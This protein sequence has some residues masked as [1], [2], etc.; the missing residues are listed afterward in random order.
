MRIIVPPAGR[1]RFLEENES[2]LRFRRNKIRRFTECTAS[3]NRP[4]IIVVVTNV[5][6][7]REILKGEKKST[8]PDT[9]MTVRAFCSMLL[10][11]PGSMSFNWSSL[12]W[13]DALLDKAAVER[14]ETFEKTTAFTIINIFYLFRKQWTWAWIMTKTCRNITFWS[15]VNAPL[16][17]KTRN[18]WSGE[19]Y[20]SG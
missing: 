20:T 17:S 11:S 6:L 2:G 12:P 13:F 8:S 19:M 18:T 5:T 16:S 1:C 14:Y 3:Y 10:L 4:S 9:P 7:K 15:N